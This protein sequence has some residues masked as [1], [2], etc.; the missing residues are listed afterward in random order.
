M[1][2]RFSLPLKAIAVLTLVLLIDQ[3]VGFV[4][5][6]IIQGLDDKLSQIG[7]IQQALLHKR[8]DVL[9]LGASC[10]KYHYNSCRQPSHDG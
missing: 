9:I 2:P 4:S 8:S 1:S 7:S 6:H 3:G 5:R 10:A